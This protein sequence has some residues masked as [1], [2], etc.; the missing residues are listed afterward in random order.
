MH[1][2]RLDDDHL[3][4]ECDLERLRRSGPG[5]QRRNKVETGVRLRHRPTGLVGEAT[6]SRSAEVNR[7]AAL[8]RLRID[9]AIAV[10][11]PAAAQPSELWRQ[12]IRGRLLS[13]NPDHADVPALIAEALDWLAARDWQAALAAEELGVSTSQLVRFLSAVPAALAQLNAARADRG[14]RPLRPTA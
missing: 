9:L 4:R 7:H 12:R 3:L 11:R 14:L 10:R 6:E 2:A 5:G 8:R 1:P 13:V